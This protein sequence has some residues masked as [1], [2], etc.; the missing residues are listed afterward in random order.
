[1]NWVLVL[2]FAISE[3]S[4]NTPFAVTSIDGFTSQSLCERFAAEYSKNKPPG[5]IVFHACIQK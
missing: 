2:T 1:M 3:L 4:G 5:I